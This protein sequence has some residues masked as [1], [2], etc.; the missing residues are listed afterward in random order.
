ML[1][2][3]WL[4][5]LYNFATIE[6]MCIKPSMRTWLARN[7]KTGLHNGAKITDNQWAERRRWVIDEIMSILFFLDHVLAPWSS[8]SCAC[9]CSERYFFVIR[10]FVPWLDSQR[11]WPLL[12]I[13]ALTLTRV[14]FCPTYSPLLC[15]RLTRCRPRPCSPTRSV[16]P[17]PNIKLLTSVTVACK[18]SSLINVLGISRVCKLG[19]L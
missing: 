4:P 7:S 19:M 8:R 1:S 6:T 16:Q 13:A 15:W 10:Q 12:P 11:T 18:I 17:S 14:D 3:T 9:F 5:T 2:K